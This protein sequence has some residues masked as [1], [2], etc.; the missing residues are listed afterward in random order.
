MNSF[1]IYP[2]I[3]LRNG[4]VVR[5]LYGDPELQTTY[6]DNPLNF[7]R[8]WLNLGAK[9]L[10]LINLDAA[11][12]EDDSANLSSIHQ[13]VTTYGDMI[14]IQTGGGIRSIEKVRALIN[15]G[16]KRVILGTAAV[17]NPKLVKHAVEE[18]G[19]EKI[20]IGI[21]A[22]DGLV[23]TQG[24]VE[25]ENISPLELANQL[26]AIGIQTVIYT[27]IAR[28]GA[29]TG[30]N[31]ESTTALAEQSGLTVIAS[32]GVNN[33]DDVTAVKQAGL[34]GVVIGKALYE[35]KINPQVVFNLQ[36][37]ENSC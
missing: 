26:K 12:G 6:G 31:L 34:P 22:R 5:L 24:W 7:A 33:L 21:D 11:F 16:V 20:V 28:D 23:K 10:H 15:L 4:N 1:T 2:A 25:T 35:Q 27:D 29:G 13:I 3:D 14:H 17:Q 19:A 37:G 32:G 8:N 9:W 30:I 36:S 18:F